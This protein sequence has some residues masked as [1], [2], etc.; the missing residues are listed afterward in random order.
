MRISNVHANQGAKEVQY[1]VMIEHALKLSAHSANDIHPLVE[2]TATHKPQV[3]QAGLP[4]KR[5]ISVLEAA[6]HTIFCN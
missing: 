4:K 5:Q 3:A 1:A 2:L 6:P